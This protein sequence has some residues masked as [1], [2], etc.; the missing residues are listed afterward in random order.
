MEPFGSDP[1]LQLRI[2]SDPTCQCNFWRHVLRP[3]LSWFERQRN[4][5]PRNLAIEE[6]ER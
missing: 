5:E 4:E 3:V 6:S 1:A 2:T